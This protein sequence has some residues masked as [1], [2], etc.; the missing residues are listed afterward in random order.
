GWSWGYQALV[1]DRAHYIPESMDMPTDPLGVLELARSTLVEWPVLLDAAL[2]ALDEAIAIATANPAV[3]FPS[4]S[5]SPLWLQ[6]A[7]PVSNQQFIQMANTLAARLIV[8]SARG[9]AER[10]ALDW[11]R[12]LQ[13]TANGLT[14][15]FDMALASSRSSQLILR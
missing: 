5:E 15:D 14:S 11:N 7:E 4:F 3:S 2:E 13:Y 8:L 1:F 12:V 6:S 10:A 9:P